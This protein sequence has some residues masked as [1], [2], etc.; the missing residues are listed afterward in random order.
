MN[1]NS[2]R[3]LKQVKTSSNKYKLDNQNNQKQYRK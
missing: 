3:Q 1:F 2:N